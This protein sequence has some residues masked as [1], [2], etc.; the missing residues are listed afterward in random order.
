M[1]ELSLKMLR[2]VDVLKSKCFFDVGSK[3]L[4]IDIIFNETKQDFLDEKEDITNG[5]PQIKKNKNAILF[6]SKDLFEIM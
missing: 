3:V 5:E 6:E 1:Y 4:A 2:P